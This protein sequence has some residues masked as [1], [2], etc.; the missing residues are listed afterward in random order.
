MK[1]K[2]AFFYTAWTDSGERLIKTAKELGVELVPAHYS[3][4]KMEATKGEWEIYFQDKQLSEFNLFYFR[5]VGDKNEHLPLLLEYA[6]AH[7]IPIVDEYLNRLGGAF[8]KRKSSEAVM[9]LR[10]GV[11]YPK[12]TFVAD[13]EELRKV[14]EVEN[15]PIIIKATAG[16]HGKGTFLIEVNLQLNK[17]LQGRTSLN[18]LVQD[19]IPNDGDFRLFL[20]GYKIV[21]G[22]KRQV[23]EQKLVL[24][25]SIGKS[26]VLDKIPEEIAAEAEKAAQV[27]GVEIAGIDLVIDKRNNKPVVIEVNQAPEFYIMEKRTGK[28][29]ASLI[30]KYLKDKASAN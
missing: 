29:I 9:L 17:I 21:A 20:I 2:I 1:T 26:E 18:F 5:S 16:R 11:S 24:D 6:K 14:V 27:L 22:F 28:D 4:L 12:S 10:E 15:K 8:R 19:Y 13:R 7:Q 23:K 25:R 30:I 3:A